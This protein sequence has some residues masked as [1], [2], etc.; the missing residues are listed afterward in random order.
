MIPDYPEFS[1]LTIELR[2]QLHP[3]FQN[4]QNGI[5]EFTFANLYLFRGTHNYRISKLKDSLFL[6]AGSDSG[7]PFFMLPFGLP[8]KELLDEL[9]HK[10]TSM[11][12]VSE[13]QASK[14]V[15]RG[16]PVV[17]DYDNF[18]YLY[19]REE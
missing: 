15:D 1:K 14:L 7:S 2:K 9:F 6:I 3:L 13:G 17:A 5:S 19:L 18:D 4:L 8:D 11:K 12:C 10:F 16:Y